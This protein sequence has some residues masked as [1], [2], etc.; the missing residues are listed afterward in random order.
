MLK[1]LESIKSLIRPRKCGVG[2]NG[3]SR[4][5]RDGSELDGSKVDNGEVDG[6]EVE[7]DEV[8]KKVQKLSKSKNLSKSKDMVGLDFLTPKAKLAFTKLRQVF[9]KALI[10]HYF[11]SKRHIQIETDVLG[12]VIGGVLGQLI[13][14]NLGQWHPVTFF[15]S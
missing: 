1:T 6:G 12:Y 3:D 13:L 5:V 11:D 7:D 4:V 15:L 9:V 10:L 2:I 14:D 8:G